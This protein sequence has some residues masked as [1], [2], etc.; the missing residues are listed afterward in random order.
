MTKVIKN[1]VQSVLRSLSTPMFLSLARRNV[2][3]PYSL[4]TA[5]LIFEV[6]NFFVSVFNLYSDE[7]VSTS[8]IIKNEAQSFDSIMAF[9][10]KL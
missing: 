3:R 7:F 10:I 9:D 6:L 8:D 4:Q 2:N 5:S 1:D